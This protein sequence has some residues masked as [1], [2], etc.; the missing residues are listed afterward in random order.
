M[1]ECGGA[2]FSGERDGGTGGSNYPLRGTKKTLWEGG[3]RVPAFLHSPLLQNKR[4]VYH[5]LVGPSCEILMNL[6]I[7]NHTLILDSFM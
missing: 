5:G 7:I 1:T 6:S 3:T 2:C 4:S